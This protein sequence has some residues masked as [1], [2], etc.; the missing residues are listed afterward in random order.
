MKKILLI[1]ILS[2]LT[3]C[4]NMTAPTTI[5]LPEVPTPRLT[6]EQRSY[7]DKTVAIPNMYFMETPESKSILVGSSI[8][9]QASGCQ[10]M[11]RYKVRTNATFLESLNLLKY[12]S[13]MMGAKRLTI[14]KHE[15]VD[16]NEGRISIYDDVVFLR[17]GTSLQ[18]ADFHSTIVAD[19]YDCMR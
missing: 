6:E 11:Q 8:F 16:A 19:L 7:I 14:V 18:G 13:A 1:T 12:R 4:A 5:V 3:G 10:F 15:E 9:A 17:A 2:A